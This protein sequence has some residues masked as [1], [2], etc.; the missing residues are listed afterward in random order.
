MYNKMIA[1]IEAERT[2][3]LD[4]LNAFELKRLKAM[5]TR[6][7]E[8]Q[9]HSEIIEGFQRYLKELSEHGSPCDILSSATALQARSKE[10]VESQEEFNKGQLVKDQVTFNRLVDISEVT[11]GKT[12]F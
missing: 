11:N 1:V 10:L 3:L 4:Q 12:T 7:D 9:R 6:V 5:H 8:C 2:V